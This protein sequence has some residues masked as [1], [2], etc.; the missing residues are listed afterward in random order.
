MAVIFY[1]YGNK[2]KKEAQLSEHACPNCGYTAPHAL[3]KEKYGLKIWGI[4][5]LFSKTIDMGDM[6]EKCGLIKTMTKDEYNEALKQS[7]QEL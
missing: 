6:C 7:K 4:I 3:V 5:P 1:S 2:I